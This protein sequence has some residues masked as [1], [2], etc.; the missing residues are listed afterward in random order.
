MLRE[1]INQ[2]PD[3]KPVIPGLDPGIH[4]AVVT[5]PPCVIL[6]LDPRTQEPDVK[7]FTFGFWVVGSSPTMT[8]LSAE[9]TDETGG[10]LDPPHPFPAFQAS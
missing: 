3:A 9:R 6:G 1:P 5:V 8:A 2:E 10:W 4:P 7:A